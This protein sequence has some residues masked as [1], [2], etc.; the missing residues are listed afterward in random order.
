M[1]C[2]GPSPFETARPTVQAAASRTVRIEGG[3][4]GCS[5]A[6]AQRQKRGGEAIRRIR[7]HGLTA[8]PPG[9]AITARRL[10]RAS[11]A[12]S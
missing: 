3:L 10:G 2:R 8:P 9:A 7:P 1:I 5:T 4:R 11:A 12:G 6:C